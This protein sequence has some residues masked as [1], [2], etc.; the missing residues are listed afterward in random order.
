MVLK[1]HV[2]IAPHADDEII[3]CH[4]I[5][6]QGTVNIVAFPDS[7]GASTE[8]KE[9]S[10]RFGYDT[11]TFQTPKDI[12]ALAEQALAVNGLIFMPDP[13]YE[14]HPLH[15]QIGHIGESLA[16]LTTNVV[17]YSTKM[18]APYIEEYDH[19]MIKKRDLD[20][21]YGDKKSLWEF[22]HRYFLFE[23][24][25]IWGIPLKLL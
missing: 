9:S 10:R 15:R 11:K 22:D 19:P 1:R 20:A 21:C 3:G 18:N 2:I 12:T 17:F 5:L 23:G 24:Y 7:S 14:Y 16:K 8:A 25:N 6:V 13:I 4:S